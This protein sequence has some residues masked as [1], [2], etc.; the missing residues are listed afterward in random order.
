MIFHHLDMIDSRAWMFAQHVAADQSDGD[1]TSLHR[2]LNA[3]LWKRAG[4]EDVGDQQVVW[5]A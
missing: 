2:G 5:P 1:F 4:G 3:R